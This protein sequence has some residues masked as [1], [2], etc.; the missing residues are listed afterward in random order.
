M[1]NITLIFTQIKKLQLD[2]ECAGYVGKIGN[3]FNSLFN[4]KFSILFHVLINNKYR[5][6]HFLLKQQISM[7]NVYNTYCTGIFKQL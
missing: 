2:L 7:C 4:F 3:N 1:V 6:K 5:Q